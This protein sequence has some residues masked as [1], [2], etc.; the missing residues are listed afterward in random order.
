MKDNSK[1]AD[2]TMPAESDGLLRGR[3]A[4][5]TDQFVEY[6]TASVDFDRRLYN[7]DIDG[8]I[9]HAQMLEKIGILSATE[10]ANIVTGLSEMI[11][12]LNTIHTQ[13]KR[14]D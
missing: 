13:K 5:A 8:S 10:R 4:E 1:P 6:F 11:E 3:F 14:V 12:L 7:E 9:A 2:N